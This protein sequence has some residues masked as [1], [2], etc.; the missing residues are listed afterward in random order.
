MA[1]GERIRFIRNLREM[2]QKYLGTIVGLSEKTADVRVAQ[3][4]AGSRTPKDDLINKLA[5]AL[6]VSTSALKVPD[7]DTYIGLMH[8]LFAIEDRYG[9]KVEASE[10][11]QPRLYL[12]IRHS[13]DGSQIFNMLSDWMDKAVALESGQITKDEYDEWRYH[14][15]DGQTV[16]SRFGTI[17]PENH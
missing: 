4:E 12:D 8:T 3:Y 14:Y 10:D 6:G 5:A 15:P 9:I 16:N 7:I 1:I 13:K 17:P 2:T 11:G